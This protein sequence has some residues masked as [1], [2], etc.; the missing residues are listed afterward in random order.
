MDL[1]GPRAKYERGMEHLSVLDSNCRRFVETGPYTVVADFDADQR[2]YVL[3]FRQREPVP[4]IFST[5]VGDVI[6]NFRSA[7]DHVAW[8]VALRSRRAENLWKEEVARRIAFPI[9]QS[10]GELHAH[11]LWSN[12]NED[13]KPLLDALQPYHA[14][15]GP[16]AH[17]F[18]RLNRLWNIDKHRV[19]H[20]GFAR[21]DFSSV[22]FRPWAIS[23]ESLPHEVEWRPLTGTVEDGTEV[24][25][26][27]F[28][29]LPER[30]EARLELAGQPSAE[31]LFGHPG[32]GLGLSVYDFLVI[33][34]HLAQAM[35]QF[36]ELP[37]KS[38]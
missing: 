31:L 27:R 4:L 33:A 34:G 35:D 2:G 22:S 3:R 37:E 36:K 32:L 9:T 17:P 20:G 24:A 29:G 26:V 16:K 7:L 38:R 1:D 10:P 21:I 19:L 12:S 30:H 15:D 14:E 5:T 13:V 6:H 11:W 23:I 18:W 25:V 28:Q 8:L